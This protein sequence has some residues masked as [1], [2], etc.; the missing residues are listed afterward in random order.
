VAASFLNYY[1]TSYKKDF[2]K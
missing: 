1:Y 2:R